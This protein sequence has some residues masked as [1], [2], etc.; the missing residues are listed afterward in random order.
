MFVSPAL[1]RGPQETVFF[2]WGGSVGN[3][4]RKDEPLI[5]VGTAQGHFFCSHQC[6]LT[7]TAVQ[8]D[9]LPAYSGALKFPRDSFGSWF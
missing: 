5:P 3:A 7:N 9:P 1:H 2:S 6:P 4:N 8:N